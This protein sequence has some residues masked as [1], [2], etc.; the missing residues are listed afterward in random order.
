M[1]VNTLRCS[2]SERIKESTVE[3]VFVKEKGE[4]KL[5][6]YYLAQFH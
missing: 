6:S 4:T 3:T 5:V 1:L 2:I